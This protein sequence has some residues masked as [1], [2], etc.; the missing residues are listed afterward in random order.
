M[1]QPMVAGNWKMNGSMESIK[2]LLDGIKQ[3]L[4]EVNNAEIIV[5][6][7]SIYLGEVHSQIKDTVISLG[8]QNVSEHASGAFTGE[9]S[10][11]MLKDYNCKYS[12]IGHS[13]RR[14]LYSET[15]QLI[16][17]KFVTL[18]E[19]HTIPIFCIGEL[20]DEREAGKTEDIV[21]RQIDAVL[22]LADIFAFRNSVIA[23]EPV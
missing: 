4:G 7:S 2:I 17:K 12:I 11:K 22:D 16:A 15:D 14:T 6:P 10:V 18:C 1:R 5:C 13:E 9:I 3:G 8:A 21:G 23:Y 20:L 19:A